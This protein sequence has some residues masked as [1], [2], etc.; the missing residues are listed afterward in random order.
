[1]KPSKY[2]SLSVDAVCCYKI[3]RLLL[4]L[5]QI[6]VFA[7]VPIYFGSVDA[8]MN[9]SCNFVRFTKYIK[10]KFTSNHPW[11]CRTL[12]NNIPVFGL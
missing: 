9:G 5:Q 10:N 1:M 7:V 6:F 4:S 11:S 2:Y 8:F 12:Q 3:F